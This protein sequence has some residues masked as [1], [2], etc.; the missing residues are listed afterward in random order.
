MSRYDFPSAS[1][2]SWKTTPPD[3][4]DEDPDWGDDG[5]EEAAYAAFIDAFIEWCEQE[6]CLER[7]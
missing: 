1:Y 2:D 6:V 4:Y 5:E 7:A 3:Y